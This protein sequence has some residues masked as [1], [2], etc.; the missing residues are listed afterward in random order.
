D[1]AVVLIK[2]FQPY[3]YGETYKSSHLWR[4]HKLWN[5]DKHR[6]ITAYTTEVIF[7]IPPGARSFQRFDD[8]LEIYV[9]FASVQGNIDVQPHGA[10]GVEFGNVTEGIRLTVQDLLDIHQFIADEVIPKFVG[11]FP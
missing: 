11:F 9:P 7:A 5:I 2:S 4:L 3:N 6:H 10:V 8:R 1:A